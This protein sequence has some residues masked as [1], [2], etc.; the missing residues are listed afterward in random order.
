METTL[1]QGRFP[2]HVRAIPK[3]QT[4]C[5]TANDVIE[6]LRAKIMAD[7]TVEL[8]AVFDHMA[9]VREQPTCF[10][11]DGIRDSRHILFC[12]SD[13]IPNA[14]LASFCPRSISVVELPDRFIVSFPDAPSEAANDLMAHW[15]RSL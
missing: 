3:S 13:S 9:H 1:F 10:V 11:A 8:I 15:V 2:L 12:L 14:R 6:E 4:P 5:S 7:E